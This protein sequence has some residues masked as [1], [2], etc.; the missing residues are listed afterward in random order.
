MK[1]K[2]TRFES[3]TLKTTTETFNRPKYFNNRHQLTAF[4]AK[5]CSL[6]INSLFYLGHSSMP[7]EL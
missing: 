2:V 7:I 4:N 5:T 3:T 6:H 1:L